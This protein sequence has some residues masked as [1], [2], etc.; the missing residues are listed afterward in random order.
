MNATNDLRSL[1]HNIISNQRMTTSEREK[2]LKAVSSSHHLSLVLLILFSSRRAIRVYSTRSFQRDY[3]RNKREDF[4]IRSSDLE[5]IRILEYLR[6]QTRIY[7][8]IALNSLV[9]LISITC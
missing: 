8:C 5:M 3:R 2:K 6:S 1:L 4:S 9:I 7:Y